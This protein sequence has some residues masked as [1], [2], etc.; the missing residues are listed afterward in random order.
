MNATRVNFD[1]LNPI[2]NIQDVLDLYSNWE[3]EE[4][5]KLEQV[6]VKSHKYFYEYN[7]EAFEVIPT[8]I[9]HVFLATDQVFSL[10]GVKP[11]NTIKEPYYFA[12]SPNP[13]YDD[14]WNIHKAVK[15]IKE[16]AIT[17]YAIDSLEREFKRLPPYRFFPELYRFHKITSYALVI[18]SPADIRFKIL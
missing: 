4:I 7:K 15:M 8:I 12:I 3:E 17:N 13:K 18:K 16:F 14:K 6:F 9:L 1:K 11:G 5:L 2:D 10:Y